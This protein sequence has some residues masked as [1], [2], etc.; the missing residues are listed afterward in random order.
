MMEYVVGFLFDTNGHVVLIEKNRPEWQAGKM[1][2]IGG[3][4]EPGETPLPA[5]IRE[6]KEE[7]GVDFKDWKHF[8]TLHGNSA[9]IYAF[10]GYAD[11]DTFYS[12]KTMED[13][14]VGFARADRIPDNAVPNLHWLIPAAR[15]NTGEKIEV[16]YATI[17]G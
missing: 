5:I 13:E 17:R 9:K 11:K 16:N 2:G 6:F 8:A 15:I 10:Y 1:N 7:T 14:Q 4:I 12:C 3:K